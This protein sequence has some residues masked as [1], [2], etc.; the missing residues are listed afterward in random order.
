MV[1]MRGRIFFWTGAV[2]G[3]L[4]LLG[5][6]GYF[7]AVGLDKADKMVSF[8]GMIV[9]EVGLLMSLYGLSR[10]RRADG[11]V[12]PEVNEPGESSVDDDLLARL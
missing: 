3:A 1:R 10:D 8:I 6:G 2:V 4:A 12:S 5:L 11:P 7:V 9:A